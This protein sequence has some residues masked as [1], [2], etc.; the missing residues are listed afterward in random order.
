M[1]TA[2]VV[3][4]SALLTN[5]PAILHQGA[6]TCLGHHPPQPSLIDPNNPSV[7]VPL[8]HTSNFDLSDVAPFPD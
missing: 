4:V 7:L 3:Q 5:H 1:L 2:D 6:L 8:I